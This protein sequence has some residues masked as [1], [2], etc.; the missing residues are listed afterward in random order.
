MQEWIRQFN[1]ADKLRFGGGRIVNLNTFKHEQP[2][3][4]MLSW[5][6]KNLLGGRRLGEFRNY[7][8]VKR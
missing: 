5:I 3:Y 8:L 1:W 2:K 4:V 6:E 7:I